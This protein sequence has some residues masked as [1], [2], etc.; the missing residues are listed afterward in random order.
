MIMRD[1]NLLAAVV[2]VLS[3][4]VG[5]CVRIS[6]V[7]VKSLFSLPATFTPLVYLA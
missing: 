2:E 7:H 1:G 3:G 4:P 6:H 5:M